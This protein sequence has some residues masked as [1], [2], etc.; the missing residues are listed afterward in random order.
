MDSFFKAAV[1]DL[2]KLLDDFELNTEELDCQAATSPAS[3]DLYPSHCGGPQCFV[4]S[5]SP[6]PDLN[7]LCYGQSPA[8][9]FRESQ[10]EPET[11]GIPLTGV[12]L[13]SSV[14]TADARAIKS[15]TPPCPDRT[16][17]PVCDLVNDTGSAILLCA[18]S[19]DAFRQLEVAEKELEEELLV[20]FNTPAESLSSDVLDHCCSLENLC[21]REFQGHE[22][23]TS[24]SLLDVILPA[25]AERIC[26]HQDLPGNS[27]ESL[28]EPKVKL[29]QNGANKEDENSSLQE[30]E[31]VSSS[32]SHYSEEGDVS[33]VGTELNSTTEDES[34][35]PED[36]TVDYSK[37][38]TPMSCLSMAVSMCGSLVSAVESA[39]ATAREEED[40]TVAVPSELNEAEEQPSPGA[41]RLREL[42]TGDHGAGADA[43]PEEDSEPLSLTSDSD[44]ESSVHPTSPPAGRTFEEGLSPSEGIGCS[45]VNSDTDNGFRYSSEMDF[46]GDFFQTGQPTGM[47]T[48]E[49][50][51][52]FL[53]GQVEASSAKSE[54]DVFS[55]L[56]RDF[57]DFDSLLGEELNNCTVDVL[58]SP[59]IDLSVTCADEPESSYLSSPDSNDA[60]PEQTQPAGHGNIT[61]TSGLKSTI[62]IE[63]P[64][65][66]GGARPKV[67]PSQSSRTSPIHK[68]A[69]SSQDQLNCGS[70]D[71]NG[72]DSD[73]VIPVTPCDRSVCSS[74][75]GYDEF[76]EPPSIPGTPL[77]SNASALEIPPSL[78][79]ADTLGSVQPSWVPDSEAPVCM[80]CGQ[81]FT[82]TRRRHHCRACGKVYCAVCCSR[83]SRLKYLE[84]EARV[85]VLCHDSLQRAQ[86]FERMMSP[87]GPSPNPN[88]PSEYC[89]TI[90]P[91][92]QARAA[93]TLNSPPPTVMVPVSV[94][95]HPGFPREQKHVWFA[96]GILPNGEVADTTRLSVKS[97]RQS[98]ESSPITPDPPPKDGEGVSAMSRPAV[99]GPWDLALLCGLNG[100]VPLDA[101]LLPE[102]DEGLP[103]LLILTG[104][105]NDGDLLVEERPATCQ[106][107]LL[108]EEGG[109]RPL[110]FVL[111]AN[112]LINIKL[113][114]YCER[115][116]WCI[117]SNGLQALGQPELLFVIEHIPEENSLPRDMFSLYSSIYQDAQ[118]GKF[119]KDLG[120]VTFTDMFLGTKDHGGFLFFS[121]S[122][123]PL[124]DLALPS[125]PYLCGVL[126]QKL[127][128][129]WAK[130]F[131][132]RLLL[133][134]GAEFDVYPCTLM[135][136]RF[137]QSVFRE[138]GHTI[139]NLLAVSVSSPQ[140]T[141]V[142]F[143]FFCPI[144]GQMMKVVNASNEHVISVGGCFSPEADAHLVCTQNE[145][146]SYQ[147]QSS[148]RPGM[149]QK[150]TGA[151]FV[152]FNG[153]LKS[154]SGFIAKSSIV[155]DGLMV[156]IPP[157]SMEA[158]RQALRDQSDF[159][160]QCGRAEPGEPREAVT[161]RWVDWTPPVNVGVVSPIDRKSLEGVPSIRVQ[162]ESEFEADGWTIKC[163]EVFYML[164]TPDCSLSSVL[165]SCGQ[166]QQEMVAASCAALCPHLS[167]LTGNN[168]NSLG[169]RI[170]T[171]TDM[172]EYQAGS[173]GCPLPQRYMNDMDGALIPIIHGGSS[174]VPHH[175]LDMELIFHI[176]QSL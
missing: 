107:L 26:E 61:N 169:L 101:C 123:Q 176:T 66:Y 161:V 27:Q 21:E 125:A 7:S 111:N 4:P 114:T 22:P 149:S 29:H 64:P 130:V 11:K 51:D 112:L 92:Q 148:S 122:F 174:S 108:L 171:G 165:T 121:P 155:E 77:G 53:L 113:V 3:L 65:Y 91:M 144:L 45:Q 96:D 103:P 25:A 56:K 124:E 32:V 38:E 55:K 2:D 48:D 166:F 59:E 33:G 109:P 68:R 79:T 40:K 87:T 44:L 142:V 9:M 136:V 98:S 137:R 152:V 145:D 86:A 1:C 85:C 42:V 158:L 93:G 43:S 75:E 47:V 116:C 18:N 132:L 67:L 6:V 39:E 19:H 153:A 170:S 35:L 110:T 20:D 23:S 17:K 139:M 36:Q 14:D 52:A 134:L 78:E 147:T 117:S 157:D 57:E 135:S 50:L 60:S 143:C 172:V 8:S 13:L 62:D 84:K 5:S 115:K 146:C 120:N 164:K 156:Q 37:G 16:L 129:P 69:C 119:I 88:V 58:V 76:S 168:L 150:V 97:R 81:K 28:E 83:K 94:L 34:V 74:D 95:K 31:Q 151:S 15:Q 30:D 24:L 154:S 99:S 163:T 80:N 82:F 128:V 12:D 72:P 54:R 133:R 127:E 10:R 102:D 100:N 89:S 159:L 70:A 167:V 90:P 63:P 104:D 131:P 173:G 73:E 105:E 160:I 49:D 162:Q 106:I 140:V 138:T 141:H 46:S 41:Q 71:E 175:A 126:L 118:R